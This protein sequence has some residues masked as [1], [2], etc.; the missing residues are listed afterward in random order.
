MRIVRSP[1]PGPFNHYRDYKPHLRP[2]FRYRC[3][4]CLS[5][6]DFMGRFD[7]ME[8]DH[9]KPKRRPEFAHL[10]HEWANLYY[11]C[12]RCN[13]HKSN[14]WPTDEEARRGLRFVDPCAEDPDDHFRL[15]RH[16]KHGDFCCVI[17]PTAAGRYTIE[18]IRLNR[19]Q[20]V[21]I[22]RSIAAEEREEQALL[23]RISQWI[24]SLT[25]EVESRGPS[26]EIKQALRG[27][28]REHEQRSAKLAEIRSLRPFPVEEEFTS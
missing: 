14:H 23:S 5:H 1:D 28:T 20:L 2:L 26:A 21:Q 12:R 6:E 11:C 16:P 15:S 18:K 25:A 24:T 13:Q 3:A 9:F 8:V 22:R 7:A 17:S 10:E 27:L 4:Y 19:D